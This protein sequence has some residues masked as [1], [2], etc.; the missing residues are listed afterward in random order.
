MV[1]C[2]VLLQL[3]MLCCVGI[4]VR[5]HFPQTRKKKKRGVDWMM[6]IEGLGEKQGGDEGGDTGQDE[7]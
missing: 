4:H 6:G 7:K 2:I 1:R 5:M 3:D